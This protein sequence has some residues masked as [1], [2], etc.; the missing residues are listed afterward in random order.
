M[1]ALPSHLP[2]FLKSTKAITDVGEYSREPDRWRQAGFAHNSTNAAAHFIDIYDDGMTFAGVSLDELPRSLFDYNIALEKKGEKPWKAGYLPYAQLEGYQLVTKD[3]AYWRVLSYLESREKD[4]VKR[5][6]YKADRIRREELLLRDIGV[7]S[8]YIGDAT[9]PMHLSI[10]Y[11]GWDKD[12]PNPQGFTTEPVHSPLE[13]DFIDKHIT[14]DLVRAHMPAVEVCAS[15]IEVCLRER[16]KRNFKQ[17]V[18]MYQLEKEG[19]FDK[20]TPKAVDFM[21]SLI[22]IGAADLRDIV[23]NAWQ[24]SKSLPVGYPGA[25]YDEFISGKVA[26]PYTYLKD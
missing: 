14:A 24:D 6:W 9:N 16:M 23:I 26:D 13:G 17:L 8:H 15:K 20:G 18:P 2:G 4:A 5:A 25:A 12:A 3:M 22:G 21:S 19:E 11:N 1:R 7:L 10:H